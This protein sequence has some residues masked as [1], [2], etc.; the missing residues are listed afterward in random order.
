MKVASWVA[1]KAVAMVAQMAV[2]T[3]TLL[4]DMLVAMT[5]AMR[6]VMWE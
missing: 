4:D 5:A 6:A 3:V 2:Q 1:S